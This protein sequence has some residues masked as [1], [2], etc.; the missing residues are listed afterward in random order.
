MPK[1]PPPPVPKPKQ[2][3]AKGSAFDRWINAHKAIKPYAAAILKWAPKY[4]L[5]PLYFAVLLL[6]ESGG[7]ARARNRNDDGSYDRGIAQINSSAHP[8]ISDAQADNPAFAIRWAARFF[9]AKVANA[10]GNYVKAYRGEGGY[11]P[12]GPNPFA[13]LVPKGYVPKPGGFTPTEAAQYAVEKGQAKEQITHEGFLR[14]WDSYNN[15]YQ[16]YAG[17]NAKRSEANFL[18]RHGISE[19]TLAKS[20]AKAPAFYKSPIWKAKAD[21]YRGIAKDMGITVGK[22]QVAQAIVNNWSGN[23]FQEKLRSSKAYL[24]SN[25]FKTTTAGLENAYKSLYGDPTPE[26]KSEIQ[27]A[28]LAR[29][30]P[31]QW[32]KYLRDHPNYRNS[33]EYATNRY[34]LQ[35]ML[36]FLPT[37]REEP[38]IPGQAPKPPPPNPRVP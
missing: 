31:D 24:G 35:A 15:I 8:D 29:W 19:F 9:G 23:V 26:W 5:D 7:N 37:Q 38:Q 1:P 6:H 13:G 21:E 20:L 36:G 17:R 14:Q 12:G 28:A 33:S 3:G 11:N 25:E 4:G 22:S 34:N 27:R 18:Y 30:T 2:S 10:G 16:A 32:Q